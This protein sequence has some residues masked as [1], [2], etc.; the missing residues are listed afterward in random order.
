M[1]RVSVVLTT[2]NRPDWLEFAIESVLTQTYEDFELLILDDNSDNPGQSKVLD[3]YTDN[4][5]CM[6]ARS[7]IAEVDRKKKVRYAVL[8]NVGLKMA[9]GEYITYLCD[10]DYY[11]PRRL[12]L[13]VARLDQGDAKAVYGSQLMIRDGETV[14]TRQAWAVLNDA[15]CVVDHSSVMHTAE[16]ARE[17]G[18][19]DEDPQH[20]GHADGIFW[21]RLNQAGYKFYPIKEILDVHR[22]HGGSVQSKMEAGNWDVAPVV[23]DRPKMRNFIG[24][25]R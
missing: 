18:G 25:A 1:P 17:V 4:P 7:R 20:W 10:D 21:R 22:F 15:F 19:W 13:M 8:A 23:M 5:K 12:E 9:K 3:R 2:L 6:V 24:A 16:V 11:L 14:G